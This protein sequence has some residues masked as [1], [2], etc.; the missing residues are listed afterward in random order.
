MIPLIVSDPKH[1]KSAIH[2]SSWKANWDN[3][4]CFFCHFAHRTIMLYTHTPHRVIV[5][6]FASQCENGTTLLGGPTFFLFLP[7][8]FKTETL[9]PGSCLPA[10][11]CLC[12]LVTG[13]AHNWGFPEDLLSASVTVNL[14]CVR[15]GHATF[16]ARTW[17]QWSPGMIDLV[18]KEKFDAVFHFCVSLVHWR[19]RSLPSTV[20]SAFL[21]AKVVTMNFSSSNGQFV[22]KRMHS[23]FSPP[24][25]PRRRDHLFSIA[26]WNM[27]VFVFICH[28]CVYRCEA[29]VYW[30]STNESGFMRANCIE[31]S[32]LVESAG[33]SA[34]VTLFPASMLFCLRYYDSTRKRMFFA[35]NLY[36]RKKCSFP[37]GR[38]WLESPFFGFRSA[39]H[40]K[41][42]LFAE[43]F[44]SFCTLSLYVIWYC[45][46]YNLANI[47]GRN[48]AKGA[49]QMK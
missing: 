5:S 26:T 36:W 16:T 18:D 10:S 37:F 30:V 33:G 44:P 29:V 2:C 11:A 22:H 20:P 39:R 14:F 32:I 38:S 4:M 34:E 13:T 31:F 49:F 25:L 43:H 19:R 45:E 21:K 46:W 3:Q 28:H 7:G 47:Y 1:T 27:L 12:S 8:K 9:E 40:L 6:H 17:N 23:A 42:P 15:S 24:F 48:G 35:A 41:R